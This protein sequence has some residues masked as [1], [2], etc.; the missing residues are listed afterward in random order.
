MKKTLLK[1]GHQIIGYPNLE[2][3][4]QMLRLMKQYQFDKIELQLPCSEPAAD[5]PLF[6]KANQHSL[7]SGMTTELALTFI[8]EMIHELKMPIYL[9][10]YYNQIF[11]KGET[12]FLIRLK[13]M[14]VT[15]LIIPDAPYD[16]ASSL[17][18]NCRELGLEMIPIA[19]IHTPLERIK[20][21]CSSGSGFLY[22][23]PRTGVTGQKSEFE[24]SFFNKLNEVRGVS[25]LPIAVGFGIQTKADLDQL[26]THVD[27]AIMGSMFL[28]TYEGSG[29]VGVKAFLQSLGGD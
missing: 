13:S 11:A 28:K 8:A 15:G 29:L 5:G 20:T 9:M 1:M 23:V 7:E 25:N 2:A 4:R 22:Y 6:L 18:S 21:M 24:P 17:W 3:N 16:M 10:A 19:T 14:S 12:A 27:L 26:E